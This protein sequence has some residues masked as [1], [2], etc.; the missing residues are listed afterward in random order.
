MTR[1]WSR[2]RLQAPLEI[3]DSPYRS[4]MEP[5]LREVRALRPNP[6]D[7]VAVVVPEFA[8]EHWWQALLHNQTAFLIKSALL[9]EPNVVVINVPYRL[10]RRKAG[11]QREE[12]LSKAGR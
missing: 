2:R 8:V 7:A 12:V 9:F 4:L 3:V 1:E 10:G 5:V 6:S 11:P